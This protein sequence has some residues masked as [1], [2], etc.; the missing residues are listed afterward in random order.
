MRSSAFGGKAGKEPSCS[1]I[2]CSL[3]RL[4][5]KILCLDR[6]TAVLAEPKKCMLEESGVRPLLAGIAPPAATGRIHSE[7]G[8]SPSE[9]HSRLKI[10]GKSG[11]SP[12]SNQSNLAPAVPRSPP[13]PGERRAE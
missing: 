2:L 11:D 13:L 12:I 10:L 4:A 1:A 5:A 9:A 6:D 8:S 7:P 3:S